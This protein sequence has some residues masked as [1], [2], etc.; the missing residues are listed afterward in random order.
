MKDKQ[1][2]GF[3]ILRYVHDVLTAEFINVGVVMYVPSDGRVLAK[4]RNTMGRLRGVF[5]DLDRAAFI[6]AM[7]SVRNG[8]RK[9][10]KQKSTA[11][12][13]KSHDSVLGIAKEAIPQDDSSLQWSTV[14]GGFTGNVQETFDR[15]YNRFVARYDHQSAHRRTDDEIWRPV[16]AKLEELNL[17]TKLQ[18]KII[19]G[20]L[21]DVTFK[22]AWKN[23]QWHVYEPVSFD[24]AEA[25][26]I[27][28]KARE[29]LGHLS[30]VVA[31]GTAE[32][33]KPHFFVGAPTD[34]RLSE[35][36]EVAKKILR[37]SPTILKFSKKLS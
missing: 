6:S 10:A 28:S 11:G 15:L 13:F 30:A 17:A 9:I 32:S 33:F 20:S 25:E 1:Q 37:Q 2:Y 35:A 22:H 36:Y 16:L 23:G 27:K 31:D 29:W 5:P 19:S 12:L 34:P 8:F 24:L 21:D 3:V 14:G 7:A 26:S 4:T 18:E